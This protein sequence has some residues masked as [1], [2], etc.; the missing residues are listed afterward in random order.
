MWIVIFM[1]KQLIVNIQ[2]Q[3]QNS[4]PHHGVRIRSWIYEAFIR[5]RTGGGGGSEGVAGCL[6][7]LR[8]HRGDQHAHWLRDGE[9]PGF[10]LHR[11]WAGGGCAGTIKAGKL[12][13]DVTLV[14]AAIDNMNDGEASVGKVWYSWPLHCSCYYFHS[15]CSD[16]WLQKYAGASLTEGAANTDKENLGL[17]PAMDGS[18]KSTWEVD[19]TSGPP[20]RPPTRGDGAW[21]KLQQRGASI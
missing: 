9:T 20:S 11:V 3:L 18:K 15:S 7:P 13:S 6:H 14:Q 5:R 19:G 2:L 12:W 10:R 16:E 1:F 17:V 8:W 4:L 21:Q